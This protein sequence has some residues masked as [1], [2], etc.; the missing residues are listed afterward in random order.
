MHGMTKDLLIMESHWQPE[1]TR[2]NKVQTLK[3]AVASKYNAFDEHVPDE[4]RNAIAAGK[5]YKEVIAA[6]RRSGCRGTSVLNFIANMILWCWV[7]A[8]AEG[9]KLMQPNGQKVTDV[10][11]VVR[12]VRMMFEGD[13]SLLTLTGAR[14]TPEQVQALADRWIKLGHRPKL[15]LRSSGEQAEFTGYKFLVD[16]FGLVAGSEVPDLPRLL[17]NIAYCHNRGSVD[18]AVKGDLTALRRCVDPGLLSRAYTI[19]HAA[20][21]VARWLYNQVSTT[22]LVFSIDDRVRLGDDLSDALP[23][24]WK[25]T[26]GTEKMLESTINWQ[27]FVERVEAAISAGEAS[28]FDEAEFAYQ[29]GWCKTP[30]EWTDFLVALGAITRGTDH[31]VV[32]RVLPSCF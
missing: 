32:S 5:T 20:P 26:D 27:T 29:H 30:E 14:F 24:L 2:T 9:A 6:I 23:E 28:G 4:V 18:A 25:G 10:F 3:L 1:R 13:D 22:N 7:L 21:T 8:G 17:G 16:E 15:Y 12:F 19:A 31:E 11:G